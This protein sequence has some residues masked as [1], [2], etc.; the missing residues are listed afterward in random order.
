MSRASALPTGT[1]TFLFSDIEGSTHLGQALD[2]EAYRE[3][4]EKHQRLLRAS[5]EAHGGTERGT[6]GDAFLV[7]FREAPSAVAAAID[8]QRSLHGAEWPADVDIR[9][10]M[11]LH[12]G[13][14]IAGGDDY[15]G[16]DINRAARIASAGHGGQVLISESTWALAR[17]NLPIGVELLDLGDHWLKDLHTPERLFQLAMEG[18]PSSFPPLR[19]IR[20]SGQLPVRLT[21]FLGR[22]AAMEDL[23]GLAAANRLITLTGPGGTGKTSLATEFA[24]EAAG[25]FSEGSW[26]VGLESIIDPDHV[27]AAIVATLGLRETS[28]QSMSERLLENLAHRS[29]MLVLDNFEHVLEAA[30]IVSDILGAAP[31]VTVLVTS[32]TPLHLSAEQVYPVPPLPVPSPRD[33][34]VPGDLEAV[35]SVRLFLERAQHVQPSFD[36]SS[37][38]VA[39]IGDICTRLDGLPLG[40]ELAA[41]QV[42]H[43]GP[44]GIRD[45]LALQLRIPGKGLRDRPARQ[46]TLSDAIEWSYGLLDESARRL[47][48]RLAVFR[49]GCWAAELERVCG[50]PEELGMDVEDALATLVDHNLVRT[51]SRVDGVRT[52]MLATIRSYASERLAET[53]NVTEIRRRHALAYLALA[54]AAAPGLPGRGQAAVIA[55]LA[56]EQDNFRAAFRWAIE[57]GNPEVGQRLGAALW[58]FWQFRGDL[59]EGRSTIKSVLEM[60]GGE[61]PTTWRMRALEAAGGL[62]YWAADPQVLIEMYGA[63]LDL[64]EKL[65]DPKGIAD[66]WFTSA[67]AFTTPN[68]AARRRGTDAIGK[69]ADLYRE[70]GDE[71]SLA[72]TMWVRAAIL[73]TEGNL[74]EARELL[75]QAFV[76]YQELDDIYFEGIAAGYLAGVY[77]QQGDQLETMRWSLPW[78]R[79]SQELGDITTLI[80]LLES[81]IEVSFRF[82]NPVAAATM[83]AA[84]TT[85]AP[86]YG[87]KAIRDMA[88]DWMRQDPLESARS[89]L[90]PAALDAALARGRAMTLD[91]AV[92]YLIET[93]EQML[94]Q[95]RAGNAT[96]HSPP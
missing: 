10:R 50:P 78:I 56:D 37:Q 32:R 36:L 2:P 95:A 38:D 64:A 92:A 21:S 71:R 81:A 34:G 20:A 90:D 70:L 13:E 26:Y 60:P 28:S 65:G 14:G 48:A 67:F 69:A 24:R 83:L 75:E 53:E 16:P 19:G 42:A 80:R 33:R 1:V 66:A 18:L 94:D 12:T 41:A 30:P 23:R 87:M 6:Q 45:R 7:V 15:V 9:V 51:A 82:G 85:L 79:V 5:F 27:A 52:E 22:E 93:T 31:A 11:G 55:R 35:P 57:T 62:A 96:V 76:R 72:R 77:L 43:L 29:L 40:I 8:A 88:P 58:R 17:R 47:L 46:R 59:E 39:I 49:G 89:V 4:L 3:V 54:E 73:M 68:A 63:Q 91:T 44:A 61:A 25:Q 86:R 84:H 74:V